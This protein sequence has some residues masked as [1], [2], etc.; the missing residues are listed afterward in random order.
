LV[1]NK[2][3]APVLEMTLQGGTFRF[4]SGA[5]VG[6]SGGDAD[7]KINSVSKI[8]NA[9]MEIKAG[10]VLKITRIKRGCRM[11]LAI[12]GEWE[13]E[14]VMGSFSTYT[15]AVF[16]GING[17]SLQKG[18]IVSW[19]TKNLDTEIREVPKNLIPHFSSK[20]R[21]RIIEGPEW[22]WLSENQKNQFLNAEFGVSSRSNRMGVRLQSQPVFEF[23]EREMRSAPVIP[24]II[25]L[26]N[27]GNPIILMKDAQSVGGYPRIA[28]VVDA[29]L[30]RL[31]QVWTTN[32]LS[33]EKVSLGE[34][35]KLSA[36]NKNH[37]L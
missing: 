6:L 24:G 3:T 28:K 33:F 29:D 37:S 2:K 18:D 22:N 30:W 27:G 21:I 13:I 17:R 34:A 16:G 1:G 10:D 11:Y 15:T 23:E 9:T 35:K 25:Q 4:N 32:V 8:R 36:F 20:Q 19:R 14:K 7:I 26:P 31:G 12:R 5:V